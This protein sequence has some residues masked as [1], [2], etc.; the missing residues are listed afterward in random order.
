M[1]LR[2]SG[3][4]SALRDA[5]ERLKIALQ[6]TPNDVLAVHA[7]GDCYVKMGAF[8]LALG[9]LEPLRDHP[10]RDTRQK[11]YPLLE[12]CYRATSRLLELASLRNRIAQEIEDGQ[13]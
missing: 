11:T 4:P 6:E 5:A 8:E 2:G 9:V 3:M 1:V 10:R 12:E 13:A 7:L